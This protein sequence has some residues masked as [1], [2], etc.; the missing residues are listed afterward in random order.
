MMPSHIEVE[1]GAQDKAVLDRPSAATTRPLKVATTCLECGAK[2][3]PVTERHLRLHGLDGR[4]YREK[5]A[6]DPAV[7]FDP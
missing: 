3:T 1:N 2:F 7:S 5:Y 4:A 6:I